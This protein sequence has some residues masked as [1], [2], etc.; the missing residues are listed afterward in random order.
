[1]SEFLTAGGVQVADGEDIAAEDVA[2]LRVL[3]DEDR[4]L[5]RLPYRKRIS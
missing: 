5:H 1:M 4:P 2:T 3:R